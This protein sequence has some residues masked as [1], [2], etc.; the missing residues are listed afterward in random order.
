MGFR[1]RSLS[2]NDA[3]VAVATAAAA[4]F[5]SPSYPF[6]RPNFLA[7]PSA[8]S[9]STP[10]SV[11]S[12]PLRRLRPVRSALHMDSIAVPSNQV[13]DKELCLCGVWWFLAPLILSLFCV[14]QPENGLLPELLVGFQSFCFVLLLE[15]IAVVWVCNF[16]SYLWIGDVY[17][18]FSVLT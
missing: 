11:C 12:S 10:L 5:S 9:S 2:P 6:P 8:G 13:C 16:C 1:L 4:P 3:A 15:I 7:A 18:V 14:L 17:C